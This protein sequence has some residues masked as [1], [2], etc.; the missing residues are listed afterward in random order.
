MS[1]HIIKNPKEYDETLRKL[2]TTDPAHANTFNPNFE[3]LI[4]NDAYL[5]EQINKRVNKDG[6]AMT[7]ILI[8]QN[9]TS[10]TVKQVRNVYLSTSDPSGGENGDIWIK[11]TP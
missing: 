4:N 11:Y 2:E 5:N 1:D 8:A 10:Y 9:N 6:D 3:K 7:G